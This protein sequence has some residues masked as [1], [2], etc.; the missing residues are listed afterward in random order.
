MSSW[1]RTEGEE[2]DDQ[3]PLIVLNNGCVIRTTKA[4]LIKSKEDRERE[5]EEFERGGFRG[6]SRGRGGRGRGRGDGGFSGRGYE[7]RGNPNDVKLGARRRTSSSRDK[8]R[9]PLLPRT[10]DTDHRSRRQDTWA[11]PRSPDR[12][13]ARRES[14]PGGRREE[15]HAGGE[16]RP[17]RR[18]YGGRDDTGYPHSKREEDRRS[19]HGNSD[20]RGDPRSPH[21]GGRERQAS[22]SSTGHG[23]D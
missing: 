20:S 7:E 6:G 14:L 16:E 4:G 1:F 23:Q 3:E 10:S 12:R 19:S 9:S 15:G 21:H 18:S 5:E 22:K 2:Y 17:E 11:R 8:S 13:D